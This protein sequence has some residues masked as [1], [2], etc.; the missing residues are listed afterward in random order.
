MFGNHN[1][2]LERALDNVEAAAKAGVRAI[3]LQTYTADTMA[4]EFEKDGFSIDDPENLW[5][6]KLLYKLYQLSWELIK[7]TTTG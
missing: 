5:E 1:H 4:L 3:K 2:L 7:S 6:G